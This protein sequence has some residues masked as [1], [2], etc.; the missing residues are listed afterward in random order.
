MKF[1]KGTRGPL[2]T[3]ACDDLTRTLLSIVGGVVFIGI[4]EFVVNGRVPCLRI[5]VA[6]ALTRGLGDMRRALPR[7]SLTHRTQPERRVLLPPFRPCLHQC[8]VTLSAWS[9]QATSGWTGA[10]SGQLWTGR[11]V[12]RRRQTKGSKWRQRRMPRWSMLAHR[13]SRVQCDLREPDS[14]AAVSAGGYVDAGRRNLT[15]ASA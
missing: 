12:I 6:G 7:V 10:P 4:S 14:D 1:V 3:V 15:A 11:R 2:L 8:V 13:G 9:P 5:G